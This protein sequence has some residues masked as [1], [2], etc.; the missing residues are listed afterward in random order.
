MDKNN[1]DEFLRDMLFLGYWMFKDFVYVGDDE[2]IEGMIYDLL[3]GSFYSCIIKMKKD[4]SL[5]IWGYIGVKVL[6]CIDVWIWVK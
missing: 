2:W 6:G 1:L 5:D 4:G 3:S